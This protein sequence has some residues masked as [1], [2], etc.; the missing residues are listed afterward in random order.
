[1]VRGLV[2]RITFFGSIRFL[3]GVLG[4][5]SEYAPQLARSRA[6]RPDMLLVQ[7]TKAL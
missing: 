4:R 5:S 6:D 3:F 1:V 2:P 7:R